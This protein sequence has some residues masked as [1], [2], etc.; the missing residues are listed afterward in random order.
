MDEETTLSDLLKK[1]PNSINNEF[2]MLYRWLD[3][4]GW[5]LDVG[6]FHCTCYGSLSN[7]VKVFLDMIIYE[8]GIA[9]F[10]NKKYEIRQEK[11]SGFSLWEIKD[12]IPSK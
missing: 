11:F 10:R 7:V 3:G 2:I 9:I 6:K 1:L 12:D 8:D 4:M 5:S